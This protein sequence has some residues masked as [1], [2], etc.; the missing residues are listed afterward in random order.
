[1]ESDKLITVFEMLCDRLG[2]MEENISQMKEH[3]KENQRTKLGR[4]DS[5]LFGCSFNVKRVAD[6]ERDPDRFPAVFRPEV[7]GSRLISAAFIYYPNDPQLP[8]YYQ[9]IVKDSMSKDM[10]DHLYGIDVEA[11]VKLERDILVETEADGIKCSQVG[12]DSQYTYISDEIAQRTLEK[13]QDHRVKGIR[14]GTY[15][16]WIWTHYQSAGFTIDELIGIVEKAFKPVGICLDITNGMEIC[17]IRS[18]AFAEVASF[19][20][21]DTGIRDNV[22]PQ[23]VQTAV[24]R[25]LRHRDITTDYKYLKSHEITCDISEEIRELMDQYR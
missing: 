6:R 9:E 11:L 17:P 2:N 22:D 10:Q 25:L 3:L 15:G 5:Q 24:K 8:Y 18:P 14:H 16:M 4:V 7:Q 12:L 19:V 20:D 23:A 1:M 13:H 21:L